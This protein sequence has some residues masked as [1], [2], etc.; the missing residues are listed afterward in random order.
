M[1]NKKYS[2]LINNFNLIS[3]K[4]WIK[5]IVNNTSGVGLTFENLLGKLPDSMFFPDY[6]GIE[7]KCTT[8]FS[9]YPITLFT[10]AF[11][12]PSLYEMNKILEKY[13]KTDMIYIDRKLLL[14]DLKFNEKVLVNNKY[15]FELKLDYEKEKLFLFVYDLYG[16]LIEKDAFINFDSLRSHLKIKLSSL[17]L[18]YASKKRIE[19]VDY[20]RYYKMIIYELKSF[21]VFLKLLEENIIKVSIACRVSRSGIREGEQRNKNLVFKIPKENI[22]DLFDE[23]MTFDIDKM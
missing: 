5:S 13:G 21:D 2:N 12:G 19:C 1:I 14:C 15:F 9:R 22:N 11:D 7:I 18:I 3:Q 6:Y 20:F 10:K 4:K 8:R 17:A 16:N 23:I